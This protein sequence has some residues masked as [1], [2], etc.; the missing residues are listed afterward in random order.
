MESAPSGPGPFSSTAAF[1]RRRPS[2][3]GCPDGGRTGD[4]AAPKKTTDGTPRYKPGGKAKV[5]VRVT[6]HTGEP[7]VGS[8][9]VSIYDKAVEYVSGGSNVPE[10]K[11]FFWKWRRHHR[12]RTQTSLSKGGRNVLPRGE[13][14]MRFLGVFGYSVVE[15]VPEAQANASGPGEGGGPVGG[16]APGVTMAWT[17]K[18]AL[19]TDQRSGS[20]GKGEGLAMEKAEEQ[21]ALLGE[22]PGRPIQPT[23]RRKFADTARAP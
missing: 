18:R 17:A 11:A 14:P 13:T 16:R 7:F 15:D 8:L 6:D 3:P 2:G 19:A 9:V 21:K 10:I 12:P 23:V 1:L 5:K 4:G 22:A 20:F